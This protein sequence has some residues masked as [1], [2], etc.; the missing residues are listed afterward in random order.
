ME[1]L[2]ST[3]EPY[4]VSGELYGRRDC[5]RST[6]AHPRPL[7]RLVYVCWIFSQYCCELFKHH[8]IASAKIDGL[9]EKCMH[10]CE[11]FLYYAPAGWV[12]HITL[13]YVL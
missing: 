10:E 1:E 13:L 9:L 8:N 12:Q 6:R 4:T 11:C 3:L 7:S 2:L 5:W